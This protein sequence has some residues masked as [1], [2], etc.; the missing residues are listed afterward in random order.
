MIHKVVQGQLVQ[1]QPPRARATADQRRQ[2]LPSLASLPYLKG[3]STTAEAVL[4]GT[5]NPRCRGTAIRPPD[6][7]ALPELPSAL[8]QPYVVVYLRRTPG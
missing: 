8:Q 6:G 5:L 1:R 2:S 3:L 4:F 7:Y